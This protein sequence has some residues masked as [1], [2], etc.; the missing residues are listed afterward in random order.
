MV[1]LSGGASA[2]RWWLVMLD[3]AAMISC[4]P[5]YAAMVWMEP[6]VV[7]FGYIDRRPLDLGAM[8]CMV[9]FVLANIGL[10]GLLATFAVGRLT[11]VAR[12]PLRRALA[13]S[14][15]VAVAGIALVFMGCLP[16]SLAL[17]PVAVFPALA[18]WIALRPARCISG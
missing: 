12:K 7:A 5:L 8:V 10:P 15:A 2:R 11:C 18:T 14:C 16:F 1:S 13:A 6:H 9:G 3:L 4:L 17:F